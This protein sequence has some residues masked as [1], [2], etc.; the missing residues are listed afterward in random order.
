MDTSTLVSYVLTRGDILRQ[1]L[2]A[3][4][5]GEFVMLSSPETRAELAAVLAR[6]SIQERSVVPTELLAEVLTQFSEHVPGQLELPGVCRDPKDDKFLACAVEGRADY[7]VSSDRDLLDMGRYQDV[8]ILNPGQFLVALHLA[9]LPIELIREHYSLK[10]LRAIEA[11]LCL[12][13]DTKDKLL[14]VIAL[15]SADA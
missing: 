12:S 2:S 14:Q 11:G 8:C 1:L 4:Q 9:R 7:L 5:A 6:R 15:L 13:K 10:T 3:W